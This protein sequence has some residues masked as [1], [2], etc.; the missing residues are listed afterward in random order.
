MVQLH[1][2]L[3]HP[4]IRDDITELIMCCS[5]KECHVSGSCAGQAF[6]CRQLWR[7]L[8]RQRTEIG[9]RWSES[10]PQAYHIAASDVIL[11]CWNWRTAD[12]SFIRC[13]HLTWRYADE[14]RRSATRRNHNLT[15]EP[16]PWDRH[17]STLIS[18]TAKLYSSTCATIIAIS[19]VTT[20]MLTG[21]RYW[22]I[23]QYTGSLASCI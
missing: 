23:T 16:T 9:H 22:P 6:G 8:R 4:L 17:P 18:A 14:L 20:S 15:L 19:F 2:P 12:A 11:K 1:C 21:A 3:Q 13:T 5:R 7:E 10:P